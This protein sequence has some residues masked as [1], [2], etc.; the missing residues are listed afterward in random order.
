MRVVRC[1]I[2]RRA[3][4]GE[5]RGV[6]STRD[7]DRMSVKID[8]APPGR[9]SQVQTLK[10][11]PNVENPFAVAWASYNKSDA[12]A[13]PWKG[14]ICARCGRTVPSDGGALVPHLSAPFHTD[15]SAEEMT[16]DLCAGGGA[17]H[18]DTI[19]HRGG[20]WVL[21]A[22]S[23]G[24]VLGSHATKEEAE[25][26]ERAVQASK[27]S[28]AARVTRYDLAAPPLKAPVRLDAGWLKV[29]GRI[30]RVG[31]QEYRDGGGKVHR[32][33]RLPEE[34]FDPKSLASFQQVPVTNQHPPGMLDARN[35]RQYAVGNVGES[36]RAEGDYVVAPLLIYD[37]EAI[38]AAEA[39]RSQLSNGYTCELDD[40]QDPK[41]TAR[42]GPY[43]AIQRR[44]RGNHCA[45]V[46]VARAGPDARMRLDAGGAAAVEFGN[47]ENTVVG[48]RT[49]P[50][51]AHMPHKF[52]LDGYE[53]E[54]ADANAQHVV[55]RAVA[56]AKKDGEDRAKAAEDARAAAQKAL[57]ELQAKHDVL[58]ASHDAK[59]V[60]C[61]ECDGTG[62]VDGKKCDECDGKG[63]VKMDQALDPTRR[64][65]SRLRAIARGVNARAQL[66]VEAR[67]VLGEN[68]KLDDKDDL[69]IKR[70][71][72]AKLQ[73]ALKLDGKG[74]DYV[75]AAYDLAIA[76]RPKGIDQVRAA[77]ATTQTQ[78]Q[79]TA[80]TA[81]DDA[82]RAQNARVL[83]FNQSHRAKK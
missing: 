41:L 64:R 74:N 39:G 15:A 44:I 72:V 45:M 50:Q 11:A 78:V 31:V 47:A 23:T 28:D 37:G 2:A 16:Y 27:H 52:K 83:A 32:E 24:K 82:Y 48:S 21:L 68:E 66:V 1:G 71:V 35:A 14:G 80:P 10:T 56:A 29:E 30:A 19:E 81:P 73:P 4:L 42:W 3:M 13:Q 26:Q 77:V 65:D 17:A 61:D 49:D 75:G 25:A 51:G 12:D 70:L 7:E 67:S 43:D 36:V 20:K 8:V 55:E 54:V 18:A 38:A 62:K 63:K 57:S 34:V 60:E 46:D 40:A 22:K 58:V 59:M 53:V 6:A 76:A 9:E 79:D 5:L 33:L 69:S